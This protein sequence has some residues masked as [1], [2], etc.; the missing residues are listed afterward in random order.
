[1]KLT[2]RQFA[3]F[4]ALLAT[5]WATGSSWAQSSGKPAGAADAARHDTLY[6]LIDHCLGLRYEALPADVI[7][8]TKIQILDTV[9]V[10]LPARDADGIKQLYAWSKERGGKGESLVLGTHDRLPAETAARLNASMAA[11]LEFDDTYEPSLIHASCVNVPVAFATADAVGR[12]SGK[13]LIVAVAMGTDLACRLSRAGSPGVSPFIVGWDPTPMYGF[14]AAALVAGRLLGLTRDQLVGAVGL[15][16]HQ[17]SG[18]AQAAIDGTHAKRFGS[19]F[20]AYGGLMSARLAAKGAFGPINVLDGPKG[21]FKQ[22]HG[23]KVAREALLDGLG[24][25]FVGTGIAPKPYPCCRGGHVAIDGALELVEANDIRPA[26]VAQVIVYSPP[27]EMMLLGAPL[28]KKQNPKTI[29]EAQFSNP[30]MVATAI[31]DRDVGLRHFTPEALQR[32]DIRALARRV[33][34]AED[35]RLVRP[36]GGPG[37]VR[38]EIRMRDG[39]VLTKEVRY[40]KGD[41]KNPMTPA[42]YEKKN[43]ECA[44]ASGMKREQAARII[45]RFMNLDAEPDVS[46]LSLALAS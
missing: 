16:Y 23:G 30:W 1:M 28:D 42:E 44:Q 8:A 19:G 35:K 14:L 37:F 25:E 4:S 40:A 13:E 17:M 3:Q 29:V 43:Y 41:P 15:A 46:D 34:T 39:R 33:A 31:Q 9:A 24:T 6:T 12:I 26:D 11:A 5:G 2:R 27:A 45:Q 20:A 22:Y 36:D 21:L 10:A 18:N 7:A 32:E 38:L